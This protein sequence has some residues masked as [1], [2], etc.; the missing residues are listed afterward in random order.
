MA[1]EKT[2][3]EILASKISPRNYSAVLLI[4]YNVRKSAQNDYFPSAPSRVIYNAGVVG[5]G[6]TAVFNAINSSYARGEA[7]TLSGTATYILSD[8]TTPTV[9]PAI[10]IVA[11]ID[12]NIKNADRNLIPYQVQALASEIASN[13]DFSFVIPSSITEK[14]SAGTHYV[15]IDAA[16][17]DSNPVRLIASGTSDKTNNQFFNTR[18]FEII[19]NMPI[20]TQGTAA[21]IFGSS[22]A[23]YNTTTDNAPYNA[24][25]TLQISSTQDD[26]YFTLNTLHNIYIYGSSYT[27]I[28][29]G[30]NTYITTIGG[31]TNYGS[32][33]FTN[34][35]LPAIQLG[36]ADNSWQRVWY[37]TE[38]DKTR[39]RYEGNAAIGGTPGSPNIVYEITFFKPVGS[40]QYIEVRFGV[41]N[42][43]S[44]VF[45]IQNGTG[46]QVN[47]GVITAN[48]SYVI[49][50]D[51]NG[52][53]PTIFSGYYMST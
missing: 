18:S 24:G 12:M 29:P 46:S 22:A 49:R 47:G 1:L 8:G 38:S 13:G 32:L 3:E 21:P 51:T 44:G 36:S 43:T 34:P 23:T 48:Q 35:A 53:N 7:I 33:S 2:Y 50:T 10:N 5:D 39:I 37:K 16:S 31:S 14:L 15:Y 17:P 20:L 19:A 40:Y 26:A 45:G 11:Q 4:I 27:T 9:K 52:N 41:H 25:W 42:R 6:A 28:Y 30:S